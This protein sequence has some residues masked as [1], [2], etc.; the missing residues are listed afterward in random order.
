MKSTAVRFSEDL[1]SY[2]LSIITLFLSPVR[3]HVHNHTNT[4]THK[5]IIVPLANK[6]SVSQTGTITKIKLVVHICVKSLYNVHRKKKKLFFS[7][8]VN[9]SLSS[10]NFKRRRNAFKC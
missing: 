3:T 10:Y 7:V 4:Q 8:S 5:H 9:F 1:L 6:V 2:S